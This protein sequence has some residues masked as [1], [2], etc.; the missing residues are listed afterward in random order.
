[1]S[2]KFKLP[3]EYVQHGILDET[4][5]EDLHICGATDSLMD[6]LYCPSESEHRIHFK[7]YATLYT[8]DKRFLRDT[9]KALRACNGGNEIIAPIQPVKSLNDPTEVTDFLLKYGYFSM[10]PFR[11]LND[12][13][14][15]LSFTCIYAVVAPI[16]AFCVPVLI[17]IVPFFLLKMS[18]RSI[19][20]ANYIPLLRSYLRRNAISGIFEIGSA[21]W[22]KRGRILISLAF[23]FLQLYIN[24]ENCSEH[25][26]NLSSLHANIE[27][28]KKFVEHSNTNLTYV[29]TKWA[30]RKSYKK[31]M[32]DVE[33]VR[34]KIKTIESKLNT[35]LPYK[36]S[37]SKMRNFG[38][39]MHVWEYLNTNTEVIDVLS[40]CY[41]FNMFLHNS[42]ELSRNIKQN[43]LGKAVY[44]DT[45]YVKD[46][47]NPCLE[48]KRAVK[49]SVSVSK[50]IVLTGPNAAGKTTVIKSLL[51]NS[52]LAQQIGY[53]YFSSAE[54]KLYDKFHSYINIPDTNARDSLFQ[55]EAAR[56]KRILTCIAE[57]PSH[58]HLC[59]FDELFSGTNPREA[60]AAAKAF[61]EFLGKDNRVSFV[62]TTHYKEL[63]KMENNPVCMQM[64]VDIVN[65]SIKPTYKLCQ[66]VSTIDGGIFILRESGFPSEI[67]KSAEKEIVQ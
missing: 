52:I 32:R 42:Q 58:T 33:I 20:L 6:K 4:L 10:N 1:M 21:S 23:Y 39:T 35:V 60:T 40:Y 13:T 65:R 24:A 46:M 18:G 62:L 37:L 28:T 49:N 8:T 48:A 45:T 22:E 53:G 56:C 50:N 54:F 7:K 31:F 11:F 36:L 43:K 47:W 27:E 26:K 38:Q 57:E 44:G 41:E 64:S 63:A 61:L 14:L 2:L 34:S 9:Q 17:L 5:I 16:L 19:T 59:I 29:L 67:V 55:A 30:H 15:I 12:F 66:G 3:I 51:F 25:L